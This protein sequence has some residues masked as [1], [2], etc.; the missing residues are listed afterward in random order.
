MP[1]LASIIMYYHVKIA[2]YHVSS[3]VPNFEEE[4]CASYKNAL[5]TSCQDIRVPCGGL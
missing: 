1:Y 4:F 2:C 5:K 3:R